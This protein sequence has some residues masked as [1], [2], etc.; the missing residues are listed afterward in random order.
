MFVGQLI[1]LK[2]FDQ[3]VEN[4]LQK[5]YLKSELFQLV[6]AHSEKRRIY[7]ETK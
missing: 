2:H 1:V 3:Q 7:K 6:N 4:D 5:F